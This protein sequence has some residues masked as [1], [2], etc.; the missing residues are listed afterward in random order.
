MDF[1]AT[2]KTCMVK[3][4]FSLEGRASRSEFWWFSLFYIVLYLLA[5]LAD[6]NSFSGSLIYSSYFMTPFSGLIS[7]I[8]ALPYWGVAVRR[9]H[10]AG[11]SGWWLLL[12]LTGIGT[13][14]LIAWWAGKG[15]SGSNLYGDP[16][17][18]LP[19]SPLPTAE[20]GSPKWY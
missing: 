18:S 13:F 4:Y 7:L 5:F 20:D 14:V 9:L 8:L 11:Y 3:R 12:I 10:D 2:V 16:V 6:F 1:E 15:D 17:V 19:P